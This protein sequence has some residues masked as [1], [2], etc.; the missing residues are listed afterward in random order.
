MR[1]VSPFWLRFVMAATSMKGIAA[2]GHGGVISTD[3]M[4]AALKDR[5]EQLRGLL[6]HLHVDVFG[7]SAF[8]IPASPTEPQYLGQQVRYETVYLGSAYCIRREY[9]ERAESNDL[10]TNDVRV[11]SW[12]GAEFRTVHVQGDSSTMQIDVRP[13][14][15]HTHDFHLSWQGWRVWQFPEMTSHAD[16][17]AASRPSPALL[18][19]GST[20]WTWPRPGYPD[21]RQRLRAQRIG[22][23]V[24][25]IEAEM[26]GHTPSLKEDADVVIIFR[27]RFDP[28]QVIAGRRISPG[29]EVSM[30]LNGESPFWVLERIRLVSAE[31][32]QFDPCDFRPT[33]EEGMSVSDARFYIGY[34]VGEKRLNLDGRSVLTAVPLVGD[35]GDNLQHWLVGAELRPV[36]DG[37]NQRFVTEA[38]FTGETR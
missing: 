25:L 23:R 35:V 20:E 34:R 36:W 29:G 5:D 30:Q 32:Y 9:V 26:I 4:L 3:E 27:V 1:V 15:A 10:Q 2:L 6:L 22:D 38:D 18:D 19:D 31:P 13:D 8:D 24:E 12:N 17:L 14:V 21:V 11:S 7:E 16:M 37:V 33:P 28:T